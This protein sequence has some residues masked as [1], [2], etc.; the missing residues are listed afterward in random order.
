MKL[1]ARTCVVLHNGLAAAAYAHTLFATRSRVFICDPAL[2][3][4]AQSPGM[5]LPVS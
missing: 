3:D 2:L 1:T 5:F 4:R